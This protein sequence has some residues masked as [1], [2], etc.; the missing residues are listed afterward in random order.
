MPNLRKLGTIAI[1]VVETTPFV[2]N[3]RLYRLEYVRAGVEH[4]RNVLGKPYHR[5]IDADSGK[6]NVP[7]AVDHHIVYGQTV[8]VFAVRDR[9]VGGEVLDAF[10]SR[11]PV[12]SHSDKD[13]EVPSSSLSVEERRNNHHA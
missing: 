5:I 6:E 3:D 10:Y 2:F 1:N 7:F 11:N 12:L 13:K 9:W 4:N 8:Y